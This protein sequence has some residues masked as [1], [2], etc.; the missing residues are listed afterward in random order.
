[1]KYQIVTVAGRIRTNLIV[2]MMIIVIVGPFV[3]MLPTFQVLNICL[4]C[5]NT[6][7]QLFVMPR[8]FSNVFYVKPQIF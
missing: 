2:R 7:V 4:I 3:A 1:M 5:T 6:I 8:F